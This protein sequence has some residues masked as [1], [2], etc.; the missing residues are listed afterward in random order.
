[1]LS[2]CSDYFQKIFANTPQWKQSVVVLKDIA[3][4]EV[5]ALLSY[6]YV[7]EVNVL[8]E[9]LP[10]LLKA[11]ECLQIK[12]LAVPDE[13]SDI[14]KDDKVSKS[15]GKL[16]RLDSSSSNKDK[17]SHSI[18]GDGG[19]SPSH[20][21]PRRSEGSSKPIVNTIKSSSTS[22]DRQHTATEDEIINRASSINTKNQLSNKV[23]NVFENLLLTFALF[24]T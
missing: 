24:K 10:G 6:M 9:K 3:R 17:R 11:A 18:A 23:S 15:P 12:G 22:L 2:I 20:K 8:Q 19:E 7:G 4:S 21:R 5:E 13:R 16:S 1:M 14:S